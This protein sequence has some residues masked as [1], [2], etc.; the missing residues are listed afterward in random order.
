MDKFISMKELQ[1]NTIEDKDWHIETED[2]NSDITIL[3]IHGGGIES[4]TSELAFVTAQTNEYNYFTFKGD[5]R[6]GNNELHVTSIHYDNEIAQD[7]TQK[8]QR[9]I[10]LHGCTGQESIVYIGGKDKQLIKLITSEL[11]DIE[12]DVQHAPHTMSGKQKE[13]IVNQTQIQ[14][15]VQLEI[16]HA[17]RKQFFKDG[18]LT[19]KSREDQGNWD[20]FLY[21]FANALVKAVEGLHD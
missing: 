1:D 7:L 3:A 10:S 21:T 15:G 5:R 9:A 8:S 18:K 6:H 12:V 13:N 4:A 20:E 11:K 19:R 2:N 14:A 16:T 17:L